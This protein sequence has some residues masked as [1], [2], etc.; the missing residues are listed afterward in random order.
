ME[1]LT[2]TP[3]FAFPTQLTG[4]AAEE[5]FCRSL[6]IQDPIAAQK[7]LCEALSTVISNRKP[8]ERQLNS[9]L[10]FDRHAHQIAKRLLVQYVEGDAQLRL[11]DRRFFI[12]AQRLSRSFAEAHQSILG[13]S[14]QSADNFCRKDI[15]TVLIQLLRHGKVELLLRL[16]RYKKRNSEQWRQLHA[17]YQFARAHGLL[18]RNPPTENA[19]SELTLERQFIQI[20]LLGAMSTGQFSPREMLWASNWI[21]SWGGLLTLQSTH[22]SPKGSGEWSG[23]VVDLSGADGLKRFCFGE[24]GD[25]VHLDTAPLMDAIDNEI[26]TLNAA[27][28]AH[29]SG[30]PTH[31]RVR[32]ALLSKLKVLLAPTAV[33]IKRRGD[34]KPVDISVQ[35]ISGLPQIVQV[36]R[37]DTRTQAERMATSAAQLEDITISP[38][39]GHTRISTSVLGGAGL[40]SFSIATTFGA[41]PHTWQVKDR[42][43]SGCR[44]RGQPSDLNNLIPGSLIAV[45]EGE[46][47]PW[48]MAVIR[49]LR[50]LMVD[51]V[52]IG[53][54]HIGRKPRFVKMLTDCHDVSSAEPSN[55]RCFGAL[56]LPASEKH[57]TMPIKT[58]VVPAGAYR[59]GNTVMLLSSAAT[60]AL[61]LTEPLEQQ[62][63]F[64]WTSFAVV[65][66]FVAK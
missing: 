57:P 14:E 33:Q 13:P 10:V 19:A 18:P 54:E 56:Y 43:D 22:A 27:P 55:K 64:V 34:R 52:E 24:T 28:G 38:T 44:M 35:A 8:D 58:L 50:R 65:D 53:L 17:A 2:S 1:T 30:A 37:Q 23:F 16:F 32:G 31:P 4:T 66:K 6:P 49:R 5:A 26:A 7:L 42:S 21:E 41:I 36:L 25:L 59:S 51:H 40:A 39:S 29:K 46:N 61:R 47:A 20:L 9:I 15:S 62:S 12:S 3:D 11:L 48:T 60:Y 63:D 45:R